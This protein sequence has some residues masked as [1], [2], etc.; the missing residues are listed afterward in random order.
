ML[1]FINFDNLKI[2]KINSKRMTKTVSRDKYDLLKDKANQWKDR[3]LEY[4][5]LYEDM[6]EE[7]EKLLAENN[8]LQDRLINESEN[9]DNI[10]L[11]HENHNLRKKLEELTI[12]YKQIRKQL[13][14]WEKEKEEERLIEKLSKRVASRQ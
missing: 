13:K 11:K 5:Q 2:L 10:E 3:S 1:S 7:N 6:L 4:E 8:D 9:D 14:Q 12:K